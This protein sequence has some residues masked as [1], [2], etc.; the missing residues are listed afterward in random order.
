MSKGYLGQPER[1]PETNEPASGERF[2]FW[3]EIVPT[4]PLCKE[5]RIIED[6]DHIDVIKLGEFAGKRFLIEKTRYY[7]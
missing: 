2:E 3:R 6:R 1:T 7:K 4:H 5:T